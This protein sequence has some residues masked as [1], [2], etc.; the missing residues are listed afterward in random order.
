METKDNIRALKQYLFWRLLILGVLIASSLLFYV[1]FGEKPELFLLAVTLFAV[2]WTAGSLLLLNAFCESRER[3]FASVQLIYD[4]I[5][6]SFIVHV[7]GGVYGT[8][9]F[10][11]LLMIITGA[12]VWKGVGNRLANVAATFSFF[13]LYLYEAW[14]PLADRFSAAI[15]ARVDRG[16]LLMV[17]WVLLSFQ[18]VNF[19]LN[20]L[21]RQSAKLREELDRS[22]QEN[23][24]LETLNELVVNS[25]PSGIMILD[26][27]G[28]VGFCNP[29]A[30]EILECKCGDLL[31]RKIESLFPRLTQFLTYRENGELDVA[32][33]EKND[34]IGRL[35]IVY[36]RDQRKKFV[37]FSLCHTKNGDL[38]GRTGYLFVFQDLTGYRLMEEE[39]K[40]ADR[41]AAVGKLSAGIAHEIRNPLAS[42]SGAIEL[43]R[44]EL[45]LDSGNERLME[46][47]LREI[48]R[49]NVLIS[50]FL[51]FAKPTAIKKEE[52][53]LAEVV[54]ETLA[55]F[56]KGIEND[57]RVRIE[58]DVDRDLRAFVDA[59][60][61]KQV[62][63]NLTKNAVQAMPEGGLVKVRAKWRD[64]RKETILIEVSDTGGGISD[65]IRDRIFDPFFT[66]KSNG[67]G[68]GLALV[69]QI[70]ESHKGVIGLK[71]AEGKGT[72][73]SVMIPANGEKVVADGGPHP[74]GRRQVG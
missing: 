67:T 14:N 57:N 44:S 37:G 34:K 23:I 16:T 22:G 41:L 26:L 33:F 29:A 71:S 69:H 25:I 31:G 3:W 20:L 64:R 62:L 9:L 73:F 39:L 72:T 54:D 30:L 43:L 40:R 48:N 10:L 35:E 61:M 50:D 32:T 46:I 5:F 18:L 11:Y 68:L 28:R 13:V 6:V 52:T 12:Y 38:G 49:L 2:V 58:T 27:K 36:E 15:Q 51:T 4:V 59:K 19:L 1:G 17:C 45:T 63:W 60:Q 55:L 56:T 42:I 8:F 66:T 53:D 21:H 74:F 47:I 65:E 70:V 7:T 24:A